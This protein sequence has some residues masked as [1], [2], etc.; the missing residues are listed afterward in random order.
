[1]VT[2]W[3]KTIIK[4]DFAAM[5]RNCNIEMETRLEILPSSAQGPAQPSWAELALFPISPPTQ[6][7]TRTR[8]F[9][10]VKSP[11]E[12]LVQLVEYPS[13]NFE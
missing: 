1:M 6:P 2:L 8:R 4:G 9:R 3:N 7:P 5:A 10:Q 12:P 13:I 11:L